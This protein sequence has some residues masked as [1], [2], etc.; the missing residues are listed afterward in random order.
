V[1]MESD[2]L[3]GLRTTDYETTDYRTTTGTIGKSNDAQN[4]QARYARHSWY[5]PGL[6]LNGMNQPVK[7]G[8]GSL[9]L[10]SQKVHV[11][12]IAQSLR[13]MN[14]VLCFAQ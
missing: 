1:I 5:L 10:F 14:E 12:K 8:E 13:K 11:G 4:E 7:A 3:E 6:F 9:C 2:I